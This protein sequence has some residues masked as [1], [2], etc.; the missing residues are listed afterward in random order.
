MSLTASVTWIVHS[1][2]LPP[3][4]QFQCFYW[5][6]NLVPQMLTIGIKGGHESRLRQSISS[7]LCALRC[8]LGMDITIII[9]IY[10]WREYEFGGVETATKTQEE[11]IK[12]PFSSI[13]KK[14]MFTLKISK[15]YA[16]Q[17]NYRTILICEDDIKVYVLLMTNRRYFSCENKL[18]HSGDSQPQ[19]CLIYW[20]V[21]GKETVWE[22][23][24]IRSVE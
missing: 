14:L 4:Q 20:R 5:I 23:Q 1:A 8:T 2:V 7:G 18:F 24:S 6:W 22:G 11:M 12:H 15:K 10:S 17:N 9:H 21:S 16:N 13:G 3:W 19:S